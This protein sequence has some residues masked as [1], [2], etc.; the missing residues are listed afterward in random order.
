M[1]EPW[2]REEYGNPSSLYALGARA[3][4]A[5]DDARD[6]IAKLLGADS[7]EIIFT[8]SGSEADNLAI[9]GA[10]WAQAEKGPGRHIITSS[11]EHHAVLESCKFLESQGFEITHLPVTSEGKVDPPAL[12]NA[13][14]PDT[15]S[16]SIMHANNETGVI[17]PL[18]ELAAIAQE[19]K[20]PF[21]TDAVQTFG[22]LPIDVHSLG[23]D[24]L[25]AS[26]HK[27]YGP[28]GVGLLYVR[29]G[30]PLTKLIHG[31]GQE[32]SKRA[33]T[34]NVAGIVG[35]AQAAELA[36]TERTRR[37]EHIRVLR[38]TLASELQ[39]IGA[40]RVGP[41]QPSDFLPGHLNMRF[42]GIEGEVFVINLDLDEIAVSTGAACTTG[43]IEPS[44]VLLAMGMSPQEAREGV[45]FTFG[46]D[47]SQAD[48]DEAVAA[49]NRI[50]SRLLV[51]VK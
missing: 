30:A 38:D 42:P 6:T 17:Q 50:A 26:A 25:S 49:I 45:R 28:K 41:N 39:K 35:F 1:M 2:L 11:I 40:L 46:K 12:K 22:I 47:N 23:I 34:E 13:I 44:H 29:R 18:S 5:I 32:L 3:R 20:I 36:L 33:G 16:I 27:I 24:Y 7:S 48:V 31:G 51:R 15:I 8:G 37:T 43:S 21:H 19:R 14:R 9:K 10:A 4:A